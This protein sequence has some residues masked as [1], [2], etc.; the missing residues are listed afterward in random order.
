MPS[1]WQACAFVIQRGNGELVPVPVPV[2]VP[3]FRLLVPVSFRC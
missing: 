1:A 3:M 2:S